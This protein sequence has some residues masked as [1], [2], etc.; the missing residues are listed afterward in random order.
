VYEFFADCGAWASTVC[1]AVAVLGCV[2]ALFA[3]WAARG[4]VRA[5]AAATAA[6]YPAVTI[7]KPLHGTEPDLDANLAGFCL[8]DYPAPVQV[9]FGVDDPAD[10]AIGVVRRLMA[11]FPDRDFVLVINARRHG[12]NRKV[13]NLINMAGEARHE[14]LIVSDS[15]IAV[16][17][18]YLKS[19]AA[20]LDRPGVGLVTCLY[21]GRAATGLWARLAAA[22]IDYH[23]LPNALVGLKLGLATPCFGSTI[24][25]RKTTLAGIGGFAAVADQLADDYALGALVRNAGLDVAIPNYIVAHVCAER[26]ATDLIHH[27]LRWARTIRAVDPAGFIGL[28]IT[29]AVPF[30]LF[31]LLLGGIGPAALIVVAAFACRFVLQSAVDRAFHLRGDD[32]WLEPLRDILS[33]AVF[34]MS[35]FGRG[36]EWRGHRYGLRADNGLAYYGE[37]ET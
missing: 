16:A 22:A 10:P 34:V 13:S 27:E 7:L 14:L 5:A 36:V 30:A 2:Y 32:F 20:A 21:Y 4:F 15:D 11:G 33:F 12:A 19:M 17:P 3:A 28:A 6:D 35:F 29:H 1:Y 26:S 8:Q 31:G 24:A 9:V 37:V 23:F 18:D 25:L